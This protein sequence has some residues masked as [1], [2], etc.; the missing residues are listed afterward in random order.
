MIFK[1]LDDKPSFIQMSSEFPCI[2]DHSIL[3]N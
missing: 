3:Y 2:S 1:A